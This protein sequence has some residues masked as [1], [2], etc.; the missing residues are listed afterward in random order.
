MYHVI[1]QLSNRKKWLFCVVR[2]YQTYKQIIFKNVKAQPK[3][4][5]IY[6]LLLKNPQLIMDN[7]YQLPYFVYSNYTIEQFSL[8]KIKKKIFINL[9]K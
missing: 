7:L 5:A 3:L 4:F 1:S 6:T 8:Q 2:I 9:L